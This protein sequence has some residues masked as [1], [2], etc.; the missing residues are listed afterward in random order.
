M[1]LPDVFGDKFFNDWFG[2][3]W[4]KSVVRKPIPQHQQMRTDVI[5]KENGY[6]LSMELPGYAKEEINADLKD[7]YLTV[8]AIHT[9]TNDE[10][11]DKGNYIRRERYSGSCSRSFFV[12]KAV[13][14]EDIHAKYADGILTL[15]VPKKEAKKV[16]EKKTIAIEG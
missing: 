13:Q 11:D 6:E 3:E 9:E 7:G 2:D 1:L 10:K 12:G 16:E 15:E 8:S 4:D 14:P 5:E